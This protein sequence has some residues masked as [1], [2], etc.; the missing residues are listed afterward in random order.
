MVRFLRSLFVRLTVL[1][2]IMGLL[3]QLE[4]LKQKI[5]IKFENV[6]AYNPG[7][8]VENGA[9]SIKE[10]PIEGYISTEGE[11]G[12]ILQ[13]L[14]GNATSLSGNVKIHVNIAGTLQQPEWSGHIDFNN[15]S[16]EI[17]EIGVLLK[18]LTAAI[19]I[20]GPRLII[21]EAAAFDGYAGRI[22][23][24]GY[25][26][27]N[28]KEQN[29]FQLELTLHNAAL[30]NQDHVKMICYGPLTFKG[31]SQEG[32]LEGQLQVSN[33]SITIPERSSS[34]INTVDVT[35]VNIPNAAPPQC[36]INKKNPWLLGLDIRLNIPRSLTI[37]GKDLD[38]LWKG[39]IAIQG[40]GGAPQ[41]FGELRVSQGQYLFNGK[42]FAINKGTITFAGD[43]EKKT[44]M[45][46]IAEK[47][48]DKVKVD[49]IAKGP[50]KSPEISFRS[51]PPM[52]QREILS[53]LLFNRGTSQ[54]TPFQGAQISESI[55][56]LSS[57]Q[58]GPDVLS[59]I[60]ST[61][62][63]DRFEIGRNSNDA[64]SG[65][66]VEVGKYIS[67]NILISVIKSDVNKI[68]LEADL[69]NR[70]KLQGQV[71]DNSEG[72]LLLKWKKDY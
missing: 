12:Q 19:E 41:L 18:D 14:L 6:I 17:P 48:L 42:P 46:V 57:N 66:D 62:M 5:S 54:I 16:Y 7:W 13:N 8:H 59:K 2:I 26:E 71:G 33:A 39:E 10:I 40:K 27:M 30:L 29:P 4:T 23:G 3:F 64:N 32:W 9:S 63:I 37:Q 28:E 58:Q 15:G 43:V 44:T 60:R 50:I 38:S 68:A 53:W 22:Y 55:T 69:T 35:Y 21:K 36:A 24:I 72:R 11:I 49:V 51:N 20:D 31:N 1:S 70:I 52:P 47:D 56:N 61:L 34:T 65:V 25:Y 45:Y 67:D